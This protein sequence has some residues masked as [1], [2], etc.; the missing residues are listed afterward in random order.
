[1]ERYIQQQEIYMKTVISGA[2]GV[3]LLLG[4]VAQ[5]Q[6]HSP[7][8]LRPEPRFKLEALSFKAINETGSDRLGSDEVYVSI[9]VPTHK[10]ATRSQIYRNVDVGETRH[11]PLDQSCILPIAGLNRP[12]TLFGNKG[13]TWSCLVDGAAG[14]FSFT[15]VLREKDPC[16]FF[17]FLCFSHGVLPGAEPPPIDQTDDLIGR[18]EV[19][20]SMEELTALH[21]GQVLEES[22]WLRPCETS[23][24]SW[25]AE[26]QFTWRLTRLPDVQPV[27]P[28]IGN[29]LTSADQGL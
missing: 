15:V 8:E 9:H 12:T 5:A 7:P 22:V 14:P 29:S 25:E 20:Y 24:S 18:R 2:L 1:M 28:P 10:V 21:V 16:D 23:C 27:M 3:Y 6:P 13:E 11:F 19:V 17:P 4:A 26:Y